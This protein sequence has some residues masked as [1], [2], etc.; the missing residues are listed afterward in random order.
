LF[1]LVVASS[2][3]SFVRRRREGPVVLVELGV[4]EQRHRA[5]VEVLDGAAVT[6]VARRF[7]VSRQ[8]VHRWLRRYA[9]D[10]GLANLV[11]RSSRPGSCPHQM[12]AATEVRVIG[13]RW[14][15]RDWGPDRIRYQLAREGLVPVPGRSSVYRALVRNGLLDPAKRK[16]RRSDYRRW[17]R[18]RAMELWQMDVMGGVHL[19]DGSEVKVVTGIDDHS[20]FVVCAYVVARATAG[21]VCDAL[22]AALR[23]HGVPE[24]ILT[25]NGKVFTARFGLGPGP[26]R[27]DRICAENGI[28]HLLTAPYSPTTTG[29]VERLHKTMRA[30]FFRR[31]ER[32][33]ATIA[34]L[35]VALDGWVAHYNCE[36]PHQAVGMCPPAER[37]RL[38][39]AEKVPSVAEKV[40]S[41]AGDAA[42]AGQDADQ[43]AAADPGPGRPP[44]V[45]RWVDQAGNVSVAGFRYSVGRVFAGE[46]VEVVATGGLVEILHAG[47]LV[48]TR[49]Q[50]RH[51][52]LER[53]EREPVTQRRARRPRTGPSVTRVADANGAVSFAGVMYRAGRA[54]ARRSIEVSL[55]AG[56]VQL[57]CDGQVIRVHAARHDPAKEH[58]AFATPNGRPRKPK[59]APETD[60][61]TD[62]PNSIR[63]TGTGT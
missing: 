23:R 29:K 58:G 44:G 40:L 59:P 30:E 47:V 62:L 16:R 38:A 4:A 46:P 52:D 5:V 22:A 17:E 25:D 51:P 36:R 39:T 28:R 60:H 13:L 20:R 18:G 50:R 56:S 14:E 54:W 19:G 2:L 6:V 37:F 1:L 34:E 53:A 41:V 8:T 61:V 21:P 3:S 35:Q 9:G 33:F 31:H 15:H 10:G 49:V 45:S 24:Q 11:D 42:G 43:V 26:V 57:A 12:P 32:E 63:R 55:V 7:G 48:A 27:F